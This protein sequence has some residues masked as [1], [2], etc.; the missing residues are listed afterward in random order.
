MVFLAPDDE[1]VSKRFPHTYDRARDIGVEPDR[2]DA[3]SFRQ[4]HVVA[5]LCFIRSSN[6]DSCR[7]RSQDNRIAVHLVIRK[8]PSPSFQF[9]CQAEPRLWTCQVLLWVTSS[10]NSVGGRSSATRHSA[11]VPVSRSFKTRSRTAVSDQL[12]SGPSGRYSMSGASQ[13]LGSGWPLST[14]AAATTCA[15]SLWVSLILHRIP[16]APVDWEHLPPERSLEL[17]P[18][19]CLKQVRAG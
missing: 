7:V 10:D 11:A 14:I 12:N 18:L 17:C 3:L 6:S 2:A 4:A 19:P 1:T 15:G 5:R 13:N 16:A 8:A 9:C